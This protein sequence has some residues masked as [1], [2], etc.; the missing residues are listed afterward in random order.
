M[1][2]NVGFPLENLLYTFSGLSTFYTQTKRWRRE[3]ILICTQWKFSVSSMSLILLSYYYWV[4][5]SYRPKPNRLL[6]LSQKKGFGIIFFYSFI[7]IRIVFFFFSSSSSFILRLCISLIDPHSVSPPEEC[8]CTFSGWRFFNLLVSSADGIGGIKNSGQKK[9][10]E[11]IFY[12]ACWLCQRART[13]HVSFE[14]KAFH[15]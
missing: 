7:F 11:H 1:R 3:D 6:W 15:L 12:S 2:S 5:A 9:I 4:L 14:L 10:D 8:S 13:W